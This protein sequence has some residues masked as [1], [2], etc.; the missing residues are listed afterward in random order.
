MARTGGLAGDLHVLAGEL[1]AELDKPAS[2]ASL[3]DSVALA[4]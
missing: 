4:R 1:A 3:G 2:R